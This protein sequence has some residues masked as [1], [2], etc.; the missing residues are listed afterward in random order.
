MSSESEI[1]HELIDGEY[2]DISCEEN[3]EIYYNER[4]E[5]EDAMYYSWACRMGEREEIP[6]NP[7]LGPYILRPLNRNQEIL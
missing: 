4:E 3:D 7:N 6:P 1:E 5:D 2:E